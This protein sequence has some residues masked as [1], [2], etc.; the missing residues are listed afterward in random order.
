MHRSGRQDLHRRQKYFSLVIA[1]YGF[2]EL[3]VGG[4]WTL[5]LVCRGG[6]LLVL[7]LEEERKYGFWYGFVHRCFTYNWKSIY[8]R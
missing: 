2:S 1:L 8:N 3:D 4:D 5:V 6:V 7:E